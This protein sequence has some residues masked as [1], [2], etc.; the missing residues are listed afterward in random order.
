MPANLPA[1]LDIL[2]GDEVR[3]RIHGMILDFG[4]IP[5]VD[6]DEIV[7]WTHARLH[8]IADSLRDV[9]FEDDTTEALTML[10]WIWL[11]LR[12][13][14]MRYNLQ[15]QYQTMLRGTADPVLMARGAALSYVLELVELHLD[16]ESAFLVQKIAA[17]PAA[18]AR[19]AI[20]RTER[21]F[22]LMAAASGGGRDAV[23][24]LLVA[25]D[26]ISRHTESQPVRQELGKAISSV[27]EKVGGALR[28]SLTDFAHALEGVVIREL[29]QAPVR[30]ALSQESPDQSIVM[31]S[32]VANALLKASGE[33]M[34]AIAASSMS[35]TADERIAAGRPAHITL[36]VALRRDGERVELRLD[37]D[38]DGTVDYRPNWRAWPIR[39]LRLRLTQSMGVGSTMIYRSDV[40]NVTEYLMLRVGSSELDAF[41]ALP[42]RLVG[43][44]ERRDRSALAARGERLLSRQHGGTV[45]LLDLGDVLYGDSID[46]AEA[47][48]V[49]MTVEGEESEVLALRV[50]GVEG[51][52]RGSIKPLPP[53]LQDLP[54]RGFVQADRR[55]VGVVDFERILG[56]ETDQMRLEGLA[57]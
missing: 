30:V 1:L 22:E 12:F 2:E 38:A 20:E 7:A 50:R 31:P 48:Y 13:E 37:D 32:S 53:M 11:E 18:T 36:R 27:I 19:G 9:C 15:M 40:A 8:G 26:Q 28:V 41:V 25:Q 39:D 17:D 3:E 45:R 6:A 52:C 44:I 23:E 24:S 54:L 5:D 55:I 21:L 14:W 42:M 35:M 33:W 47:T 10:P 46:D 43:H 4:G 57:A 51:I 49:H 56:R 34:A 29:G 16:A